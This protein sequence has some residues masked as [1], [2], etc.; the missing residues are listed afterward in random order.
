MKSAAIYVHLETPP[1]ELPITV[2][3][4]L[5]QALGDVCANHPEWKV[6]LELYASNPGAAVPDDSPI[7]TAVRKAHA[8]V[9]GKEPGIGAVP[10]H[11]DAGHLNRYG[12][13]TVNYGVSPRTGPEA[14]PKELGDSLHIDDLVNCTRVYVDLIVRVCGVST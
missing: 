11:S 10:W 3:H 7:V 1:D 6:S 8:H 13:P 5:R 4:E 14:A 9:F 2:K 12:V